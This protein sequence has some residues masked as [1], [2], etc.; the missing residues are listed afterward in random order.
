MTSTP[1]TARSGGNH[2]RGYKV[3]L[4][5]T[6]ND[7]TPNV[8]TH[9]ET[10]MAT[11]Q[12]VTVVDTIHHALAQQNHL[13]GVH[14]VDGAYTSGEK[15]ASSQ[16]EYQIDLMGPMRQDQSW[17]DDDT[18]AFYISH[19]QIDW[20]QEIVLCPLG[21]QSRRWKPSKGPCR[22]PLLPWECGA[23][24]IEVCTRPIFITLL[25]RLPLI[26]NGS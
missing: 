26:F 5:E 25:P 18:K 9:V 13:P 16:S 24:G 10:T 7:D 14:L 15:L 6:C 22:K 3:P 2:W 20:E 11:D 21:K 19:L 12:D 17:Q 23:H 8:I 4:T 1:G